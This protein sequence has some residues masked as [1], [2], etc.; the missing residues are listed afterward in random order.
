M[1]ALYLSLIED[2]NDKTLFEKIY[3][4]YRKQMFVV[5]MQVLN[6][7][8][9]AEDVVHDVFLKI[10]GKYMERIK[11]INNSQDMRNY[12]L[13]AVKNTALNQQ[14]SKKRENVSLNTVDEWE[15]CGIKEISDNSFFQVI[16]D[17]M[18]YAS[19]LEAI[20]NLDEKYSDAIY[21]HLVIGL[22]VPETAALL[23]EKRDTVKKQLGRGKK[24]LLCAL[25]IRGDEEV[26]R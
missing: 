13:K 26:C 4:A 15:S 25:N 12:L 24:L 17:K 11:Q 3:M 8:E 19:A 14:K 22:T 21:Y 10:A 2:E 23:G 1:I 20:R 16:C 7:H 6:N 9:D 5:A 18:D